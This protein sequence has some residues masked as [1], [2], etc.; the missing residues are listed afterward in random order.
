VGITEGHGKGLVTKE[1]FDRCNINPLHD[2]LLDKLNV[3]IKFFTLLKQIEFI[4]IR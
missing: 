4:P 2:K 3:T 1:L